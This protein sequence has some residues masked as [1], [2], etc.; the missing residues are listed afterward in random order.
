MDIPDAIHQ[1]GA[2]MPD[3]HPMQ[4]AVNSRH[5]YGCP[6]GALPVVRPKACEYARSFP[7]TQQFRL[8]LVAENTDRSLKKLIFLLHYL[9]RVHVKLQG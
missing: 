7:C 2:L 5:G 9:V 4:R 6:P 1:S 8:G 3:R